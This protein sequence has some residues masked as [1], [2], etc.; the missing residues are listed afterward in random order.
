MPPPDEQSAVPASLINDSLKAKEA[1]RERTWAEC[2]IEQKVERL[3]SE[4]MRARETARGAANIAS[5]AERVA[6]CHEHN[7]GGRVLVSPD[8]NA[9]MESGNRLHPYPL[10]YVGFD[11]LA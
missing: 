6:Q 8:S 4:L 1:A 10:G 5:S 11:P 3:R 7:A 9:V 2:G